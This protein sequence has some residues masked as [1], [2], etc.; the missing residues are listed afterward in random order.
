[1]STTNLIIG[2]ALGILLGGLIIVFR[3][4]YRDVFATILVLGVVVLAVAVTILRVGQY[5]EQRA[6]PG[7]VAEDQAV[8]P[9]VGVPPGPPP[10]P[11]IGLANPPPLGRGLTGSAAPQAVENPY[12]GG[13]K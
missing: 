5:R 3:N 12:A 10:K 11:P 2:L 7:S 9:G 6:A 8:P 4:R 13:S 1:M